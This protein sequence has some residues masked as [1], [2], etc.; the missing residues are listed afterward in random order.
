MV[1]QLKLRES[2][3]PPG[4]QAGSYT[5]HTKAADLNKVGGFRRSG[6]RQLKSPV[7]LSAMAP[8]PGAEPHLYTSR[9]DHSDPT[10]HLRVSQMLIQGATSCELR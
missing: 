10:V 7:P 5:T 8:E 1:L 9:S 2:R 3:S 4:H 6:V